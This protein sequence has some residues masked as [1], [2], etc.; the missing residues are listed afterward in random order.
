MKAVEFYVFYSIQISQSYLISMVHILSSVTGTRTLKL[1]QCTLCIDSICYI[2]LGLCGVQRTLQ[3]VCIT[4]FMVP[5]PYCWKQGQLWRA[6]DPS[7]PPN[8]RAVLLRTPVSSHTYC[9]YAYIKHM[10]FC[11][12][13]CAT[14][15]KIPSRK[16]YIRNLIFKVG[17]INCNVI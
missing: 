15:V 16:V 17:L 1:Q 2:D 7:P 3:T 13:A 14:N 11:V 5:E 12:N 4:S 9:M 10:Q 8:I 6:E